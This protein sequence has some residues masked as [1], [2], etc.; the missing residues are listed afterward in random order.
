MASVFKSW[1]TSKAV[2]QS[3]RVPEGERIYAIGDIHGRLDLFD[4][5][6]LEIEADDA[7]RDAANTTIILL[8][9]LVD[10]GPASSGV[11]EAAIKLDTRKN[12]SL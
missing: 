1:F 4:Q 11:V 12:P 9:D 10:R 3:Y 8:G 7:A 6:V 5:L 2:A